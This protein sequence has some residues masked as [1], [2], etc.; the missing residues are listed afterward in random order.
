MY[1]PRVRNK[2]GS[3]DARREEGHFGRRKNCD[4]KEVLPTR[5][6]GVLVQEKAKGGV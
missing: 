6:G 5:Y 1:L 4:V 2:I 3:E